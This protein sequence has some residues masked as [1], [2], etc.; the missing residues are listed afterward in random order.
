MSFRKFLRFSTGEWLIHRA[1]VMIALVGA[2][3]S[4]VLVS[5]QAA[6][7][8][9]HASTST[10][11]VQSMP[12][13]TGMSA[14]PA[15]QQTLARPAASPTIPSPSL[16][17]TET[18]D[19]ERAN[20]AQ[21][22]ENWCVYAGHFELQVPI[23]NPPG[24]VFDPSYRYDNTQNG[25]REP[26]AGLEFPAP[27][28]ETVFPAADGRVAYAGD[29]SQTRFGE[30]KDLYGNL[31]IVEH[32]FQGI[33]K[34]LYSLYGH[35]SRIDVKTG[36]TVT[37][38]DSL[39]LVGDSGGATGPH[40]HFEIRYGDMDLNDRRNPELWLIP[41]Q[42]E[43]GQPLGVLAGQIIGPDG[44]AVYLSDVTVQYVGE[45]GQP[46]TKS[47]YLETYAD[48]HMHGDDV[49]QENFAASNLQTGWYNVAFIYNGQI[50]EQQIEI[51]PGQLTLVNFQVSSP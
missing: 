46:V 49:W 25:K 27:A 34:P 35:L 47:L 36:Q 37:T 45:I 15:P 26:H 43:D 21:C 18:P 33:A 32:T 1:V 42:D 22:H 4:P 20:P 41:G 3:C 28:G 12:T 7:V 10:F 40:L 24:N 11:A 38:Q 44:K 14:S 50:V 29:D 23:H 16:S 6:L 39:G 2:G 8:P 9:E 13:S 5:T 48:P 17:S 30:W 51:D 19:S 31:V